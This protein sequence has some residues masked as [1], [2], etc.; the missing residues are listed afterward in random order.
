MSN[1]TRL[2][3]PARR[4]QL[5][6]VGLTLARTTPFDQI[7]ADGVARLAGVSKGLVFHYFPTTRD[8]QVAV[9]RAG[10]RELM[11]DL[12]T[13]P[14]ATI[15]ERLRSGVEVFMAYIELHPSG[16]LAMARGAGSDPQLIE[17]FEET[18]AE[19]VAVIQGVLGLD[20]LPPG[21]RIAIRAWIAGVEEAV[22]H[23]L[24]GK[25]I[26]RDRLVDFL[27]QV[28]LTML[29]AAASMDAVSPRALPHLEA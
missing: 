21:L 12:D 14:T 11:D 16:Y 15:P 17:V 1:R 28:G 18:R 25:P 9:L 8:L 22:L 29:P 3:G 7:S 10:I 23:W 13:D 27:T 19:A 24:D 20:V 6:E 2:D 26:P 5:V 4:D